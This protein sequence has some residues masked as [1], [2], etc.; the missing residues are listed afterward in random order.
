MSDLMV[1]T[2]EEIRYFLAL[3]S[4]EPSD[5][6]EDDEDKDD[7]V[8]SYAPEMP[9]GQ[10]MVLVLGSKG[11]GKTSILERFCHGTFVEE[12]QEDDPPSYPDE[13][14]RGYRHSIKMEDQTYIVNALELPY[15]HLS[16]EERFKQAVQITEAAVLVY[17]VKSRAS[18][19]TV[20]EI[21][22]HIHD[23]ME[24]PRM[25]SLILVGSNSDCEDEEREVPWAEGYKLAESFKLSCTF[26]ETSAKTGENIDK[27]FPQLGKDVL[28]LRW[29]NRQREGEDERPSTDVQRD[30][31]DLTPSKR[32][33][34][35]RSW[36]QRIGG[37]R[38]T[39]V[40]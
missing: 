15:E 36:F 19:S 38:K 34:R 25:Y 21:H 29:L 4:W 7:K 39:S 30:S 17:D 11:C 14:E 23:T 5:E 9:A 28:R 20:S 24:E 22:N 10:F 8:R 32:V 13:Q 33:G 26:L 1:L 35:W 6:S 40:S 2:E 18:F 3:L 37:E 27:L 12:A 16:D 31:I